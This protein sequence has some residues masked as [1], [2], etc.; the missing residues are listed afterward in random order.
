MTRRPTNLAGRIAVG[1]LAFLVT[2]SGGAYWLNSRQVTDDSGR[3]PDVH[4]ASSD[5][6]EVYTFSDLGPAEPINEDFTSIPA[7]VTD[8]SQGGDLPATRRDEPNDPETPTPVEPDQSPRTVPPAGDAPGGSVPETRPNAEFPETNP[9]TIPGAT[10]TWYLPSNDVQAALWALPQGSVRSWGMTIPYTDDAAA[11]HQRLRDAL[12]ASGFT[13][14]SDNMKSNLDWEL[15]AITG[16]YQGW[17]FKIG[18]HE[19]RTL[20]LAIYDW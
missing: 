3:T 2:F 9:L 18:L 6:D 15:H 17:A 4:G 11:D 10:T 1:A 5:V 13:V 20:T 12:T 19:R 16:R 7:D 14:I 8:E